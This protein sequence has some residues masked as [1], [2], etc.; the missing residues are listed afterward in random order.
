MFGGLTCS[1][2]TRGPRS[3]DGEYARHRYRVCTMKSVLAW[4][5]NARCHPFSRE[6]RSRR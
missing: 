2:S 3:S 4:R 1:R 5:R 6:R